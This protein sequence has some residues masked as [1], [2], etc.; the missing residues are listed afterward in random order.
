LLIDWK[1]TMTYDEMSNEIT[2]RANAAG[3]QIGTPVVWKKRTGRV[4][5]LN[6][7][8]Y[9]LSDPLVWVDLDPKQ[10]GKN[11]P[12][13]CLINLSELTKRETQ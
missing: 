13:R 3:F 4:G 12:D 9:D 6:E 5:Q 10:P 11:R 1:K 2:A 8:F 7:F